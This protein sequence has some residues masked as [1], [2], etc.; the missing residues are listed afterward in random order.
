MMHHDNKTSDQARNLDS[1][2]IS[3]QRRPWSTPAIIVSDIRQSGA[4]VNT[5]TD[6]TSP[7]GYQYGS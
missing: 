4:S 3:D 7:F 6:G 1:D 2:H 5:F